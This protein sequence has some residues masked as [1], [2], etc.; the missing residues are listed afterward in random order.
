MSSR[1]PPGASER[2]PG[3]PSTCVYSFP[4]CSYPASCHLHPC[5]CWVTDG[6][7]IDANTPPPNHS[8][9]FQSTG[10]AQHNPKLCS[11]LF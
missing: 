11:F 1:G 5:P 7:I 10:S 6:A 3:S 8:G 4:L 2:G 9:S